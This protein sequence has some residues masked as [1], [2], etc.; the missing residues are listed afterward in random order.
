MGTAKSVD[1]DAAALVCGARG[2]DGDRRR[3]DLHHFDGLR[4]VGKVPKLQLCGICSGGGIAMP[5]AL[6]PSP[7]ALEAAVL[8][9]SELH[10]V[11]QFRARLHCSGDLLVTAG[12][13]QNPG[14]FGGHSA[15]FNV[16]PMKSSETVLEPCTIWDLCL[17]LAL[18]L[19]RSIKEVSDMGNLR[20]Q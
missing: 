16:A 13:E 14:G 4:G 10:A 8:W 19:R 5:L 7:Q 12:A 1:D 3:R 11:C 6:Q 9:S 18:T 17:G 20:C 15:Q 2:T